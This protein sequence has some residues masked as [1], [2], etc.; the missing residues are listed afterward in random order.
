MITQQELKAQCTPEIIKKMCELAEG[1]NV[2]FVLCFDDNNSESRDRLVSNGSI[3]DEAKICDSL[4][5]PLLIHRAVEGWNKKCER[6]GRILCDYDLGMIYISGV[7]AK[8]FKSYQ[9]QSLTHAE[10]AMLHCL[11]EVLR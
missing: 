2:K 10:C 8:H 9:L 6:S 11:L 7:C 4:F 1:F 5:F 3:T